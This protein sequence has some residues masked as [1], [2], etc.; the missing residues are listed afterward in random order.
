MKKLHTLRISNFR[1]FIE[2][3]ERNTD[4]FYRSPFGILA[5]L[6]KQILFAKEL[7]PIILIPYKNF[8]DAI[9]EFKSIDYNHPIPRAY[10]VFNSV[11]S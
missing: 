2:N 6:E 11:V 4:S 8:G 9:F 3:F 7:P 5:E 1:E 10:Y